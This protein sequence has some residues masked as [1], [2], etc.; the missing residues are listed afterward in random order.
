MIRRSRNLYVLLIVFMVAW[1]ML[2]PGNGYEES[3]VDEPTA[4]ATA[5]VP[6]QTPTVVVTPEP[7]VTP[8]STPVVEITP[9]PTIIPVDP[10]VVISPTVYPPQEGV[11][12]CKVDDVTVSCPTC[13]CH[14]VN[15]CIP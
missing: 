14:N 3:F 5:T 11:C 7:T 1:F 12:F 8:S 15:Q 13:K 9:D 2:S 6:V 10:T 4:I